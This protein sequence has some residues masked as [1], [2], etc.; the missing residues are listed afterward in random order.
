MKKFFYQTPNS[1]KLADDDI[2]R[3]L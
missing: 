3:S 1:A 2:V